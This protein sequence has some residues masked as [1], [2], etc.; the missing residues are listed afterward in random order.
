M[1][2]VYISSNQKASE[3]FSAWKYQQN[4]LELEWRLTKHFCVQ[5]AAA[6]WN[7]TPTRQFLNTKAMLFVYPCILSIILINDQQDATILAYLFIPNQLYMFSGDVFAHHQEHV[8]VFTA[9]V[10]VHRYCC[11]LVSW[12]RRNSISSMTTAGSNIGGQ[13]QKL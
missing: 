7:D 8:T 5:T 4:S 9:S 12:M 10:I 11:R 3:F 13:Y 1:K 6:H 2:T